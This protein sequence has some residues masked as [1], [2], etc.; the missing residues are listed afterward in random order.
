MLII[1]ACRKSLLVM[2]A[3]VNWSEDLIII[4]APPWAFLSGGHEEKRL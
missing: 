4:A 3:G 2:G 1:A